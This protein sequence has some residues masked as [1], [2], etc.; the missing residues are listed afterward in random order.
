MTRDIYTTRDFHGATVHIGGARANDQNRTH[1]DT[2]NQ[3]RTNDMIISDT[4]SGPSGATVSP[5]RGKETSVS[6]PSSAASSSYAF[7]ER[8]RRMNTICSKA[9]SASY[10]YCVYLGKR[11]TRCEQSTYS[12]IASTKRVSSISSISFFIRLINRA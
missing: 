4:P 1:N 11:M 3:P 9:E 12:R 7:N 10:R 5:T 2:P 8:P 6:G